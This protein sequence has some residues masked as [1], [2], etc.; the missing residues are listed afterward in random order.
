MCINR[1]TLLKN[2]KHVNVNFKL[3]RRYME[4]VACICL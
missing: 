3:Y 1:Q 4:N 2:N